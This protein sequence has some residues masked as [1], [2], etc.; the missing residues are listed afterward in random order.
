MAEIG[1]HTSLLVTDFTSAIYFVVA[2]SRGLDSNPSS[3]V[4]YQGTL[5]EG[6]G[7]VRLTSF[8]KFLDQLIFIVKMLSY[9]V[10]K[11]ATLMRRSQ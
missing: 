7:S 6:D 5:T 3:S 2:S 8:Y 10:T 9:F 11:Q 4:L 1:K